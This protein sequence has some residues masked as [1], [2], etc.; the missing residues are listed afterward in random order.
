[1]IIV[2]GN[3]YWQRWALLLPMVIPASSL[4]AGWQGLWGEAGLINRALAF[5]GWKPV[6]FMYGQAAL[7]LLIALY[8]LKIIGYVSVILT[9]AIR[10]LPPE[11][12]ECYQ[13]DSSR[14]W[15]YAR[16]VLLP[17]IS[18]TM[19]FCGI[20]AVMNYFLMYRDMYF[21]YQDNPPARLY[22]LQHFM[23]NNFYK[24]NY[25]RLGAA[26]FLTVLLLSALIAAVLLIQRRVKHY[27][28]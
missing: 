17:L 21:L 18:P 26:A 4:A 11:Y 22:M 6:D 2:K 12:R 9:S 5:F 8:L 10:S 27:V 15:G 1:M 3:F 20:V 7:P 13:L 23:N 14:E 19:L 24:L 16:R 28:G 25:Q